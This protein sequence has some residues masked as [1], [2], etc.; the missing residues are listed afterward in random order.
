MFVPREEEIELVASSLGFKER[1]LKIARARDVG[2]VV[3]NRELPETMRRQLPDRRKVLLVCMV[4]NTSLN[5]ARLLAR[6]GI[7]A[8]SLVGG[9]MGL[10]AR[11]APQPSELVQ[12]A[13]E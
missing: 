12:I 3:S 7:A 1:N 10:A 11:V 8:E 4:G 13:S 2:T 5:V 9:I 6:F